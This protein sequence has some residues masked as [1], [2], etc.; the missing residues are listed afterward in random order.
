MPK[1]LRQVRESE[2]LSRPELAR[3]A[4]LSDKTLQRAENGNAVSGVTRHKIV[5]ALN[6][7]TERLQKY[8]VSDLFPDE[9]S[10]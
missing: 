1:R 8:D 6:R 7:R 2:G 9:K 10:E 3:A 4:G 5:N